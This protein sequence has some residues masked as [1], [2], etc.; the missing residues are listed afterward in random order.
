MFNFFKKIYDRIRFE[1]YY[2][3]QLKK[4]KENADPYIYK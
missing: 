1:I 4:A 2:R 3:Q